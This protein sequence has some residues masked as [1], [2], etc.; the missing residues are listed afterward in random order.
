MEH[1]DLQ[2]YKPDPDA[3]KKYYRIGVRP[4]DL[5]FGIGEYYFGAA[6]RDGE[7]HKDH[8]Q[9]IANNGDNFGLFGEHN[10]KPRPDDPKKKKEYK[11]LPQKYNAKLI[12]QAREQVETVWLVEREKRLQ[13]FVNDLRTDPNSVM[14]KSPI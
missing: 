7:Q 6:F 8:M 11:F 10:A 9:L 12:E 3:P 1:Q 2:P 13:K 14:Q 5:G 4:L